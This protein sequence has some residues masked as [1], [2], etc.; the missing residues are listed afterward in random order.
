MNYTEAVEYNKQFDLQST[1]TDP[2]ARENG[3]H[4]DWVK[5]PEGMIGVLA[6]QNSKQF[7]VNY[8][9][10][11]MRV[12]YKHTVRCYPIEQLND[13]EILSFKEERK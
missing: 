5:S 6:G 4:L 9:V 3:K 7:L 8:P 2:K 10:K 1:W 12:N 11:V 13:F